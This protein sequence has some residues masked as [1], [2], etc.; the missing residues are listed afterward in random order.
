M[1]KPILGRRENDMTRERLIRLVYIC[2]WS[3]LGI[4]YGLIAVFLTL[5]RYDLTPMGS[6]LNLLDHAALWT[7]VGLIF[8]GFS[9]LAIAYVADIIE[10]IRGRRSRY[11][12]RRVR[13]SRSMS[14]KVSGLA[15]L[16]RARP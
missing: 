2:G 16:K 15:G 3:A 13:A 4:G 8:S 11:R 10:E 14:S 7:S 6:L 5:E 12:R 9:A 1:L